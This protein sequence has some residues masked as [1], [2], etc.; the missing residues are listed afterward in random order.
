MS[1]VALRYV[2]LLL[3]RRIALVLLGFTALVQMFDLVGNADDIA[4]K[5][6]PGVGAVLVY[7]AYRLP[8]MMA[9][10]MPFSILVGSLITL[11]GM[12]NN[13]EVM[14][15]K[16]AGMS[17]YRLLLCLMPVGLLFAAAH[18]VIA[19]RLA[20][21]TLRALAEREIVYTE[22]RKTARQAETAPNPAWIRDG[23]TIVRVG[24]VQRDGAVL[25]D[26]EI[27]RRNQSGVMVQR[28]QARVAI[29][30]PKSGAW[31]LTDVS[32][33]DIGREER[34]IER[35]PLE[36]WATKLQ[37]SDFADLT[38]PPNQFTTSDLLSLSRTAG[39]GSRPIFVYETWLHKR[40]ALP[41]LCLLMVV[42]AAPVSQA[43]LRSR[44]TAARMSLGIGLGF[45][46]FV[47]DG[48]S[49]A[50]GETGSLLPVLAA[51]API[52]IF[53]SVGGSVLLR[54]EQV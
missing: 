43:S 12:A 31:T 29:F 28:R 23:D 26:V 41:V 27:I 5:Y 35:R 52:A 14:A 8:P 44:G 33:L 10:V 30:E 50:L 47:S 34:R 1:R 37:P 6:G 32:Q 49:T 22:Q 40:L 13:N 19:D 54:V 15:F 16:A 18:F 4:D 42:L 20:P 51:W 36:Q 11:L 17:F 25:F 9:L 24:R 3:L 45:L 2:S 39:V 48:L 7:V 53:A 46:F 21:A 38:V